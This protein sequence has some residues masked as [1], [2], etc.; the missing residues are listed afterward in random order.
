M[1]NE[2]TFHVLKYIL[3]VTA[4]KIKDRNIFLHTFK[5]SARMRQLKSRKGQI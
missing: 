3:Y 2:K 1:W 4:F 5:G